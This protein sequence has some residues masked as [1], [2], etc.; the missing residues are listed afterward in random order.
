MTEQ[1]L[2]VDDEPAMGEMLV[3][4]LGRRGIR[5]TW[6]SSA[7]EALAALEDEAFDAVVT[8][9]RMTGMQGIELCSHIVAGC[10][11]VPV[12]V[13]TAFGSMETAVAAMRAGAYDF[14]T[15]PLDVDALL[16]TLHRA[17]ERRELREEVKRLRRV[18]RETQSFGEM[19]G[20]SPPMQQLFSLLQRVAESDA[21]VLIHGE[22][23]TGKELVARALHRMGKRNKGPFVAINCSAVPETLLE[24]EL[25]GHEAGAFTDAK[26]A[27]TGLFVQADGGILFLDEIGDLP[28]GLQPKLLRALQERTVRPVGGGRETAFDV[29]LVAATHRDLEADV[30]DGRFREDLFYRIHVL[31]VD[32]PP[33]RARGNDVLLL[34]Q[35]FL[36]EF[37]VQAGKHVTGITSAAAAKLLAYDWP[38][39]VREL[40]NYIERAVGAWA[41]VDKPFELEDLQVLVDEILDR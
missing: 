7:A 19:L 34:A 10:P 9:V 3:E 36:E 2:V 22:S 8:D 11:D 33:L 24:T 4:M 5:C 25:F 26:S 29:R 20:S 35:R 31:P 38:G 32:V 15:K 17:F 37:A 28:L 41:V 23:G 27:R 39:N 1:V 13:V 30:E 21:S 16:L 6:K 40:R 14:V 12:V 18:V